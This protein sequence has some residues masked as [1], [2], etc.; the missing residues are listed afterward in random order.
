MKDNNINENVVEVNN[1]KAFY[2]TNA[3]GI[4]RTVRAVDD[5]S[6]S[7]KEGEIYGLAGESGC[8]KSSLMKVMMGAH[9]VPL[10]IVD[11]GIH[12]K[13]GNNQNIKTID[14]QNN[15]NFKW[16]E[17]SYIPQG[18]MN[19]LN[20]VR[21]IKDIFHDF[22]STDGI[23]SKKDSYEM[24]SNYLKDLG[25]QE[26]VMISYPHQL[27]G[28]MRQ[29]VTIALAT[30]LWPKVIYADEPTTALDVVVQRGVIQ[31]LKE[32]QKEKSTII[33]ITHDLGVHANLAKRI[34]ILYA[35]KLV[36]ESSAEKIL[37]NPKHPYTKFLINSLPSIDKKMIL[38][39][40]QGG[41]LH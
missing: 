19:V 4:Q 18:S 37:K 22:I 5:I 16:N 25:L 6:L 41:L 15:L 8:G 30:I 31:L 9:K 20:P 3:Y 17:V 10:T 1:L 26:K 13:T 40:S 33:L 21:K 12:Y 27:S 23:I 11:G 28:G 32:I 39:Q 36:E 2:I 38:N 14:S 34:G 7:I 29:R 24:T 35:G